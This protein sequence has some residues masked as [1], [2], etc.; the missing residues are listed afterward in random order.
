MAQLRQR[1]K[2]LEN[3]NAELQ[4][5]YVNEKIEKEKIEKNILE[6]KEQW[7]REKIALIELNQK[8][9]VM[10]EEINS[11]IIDYKQTNN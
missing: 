6:E 1:L 2:E 4:K 7:N 5:T 9:S 10:I 8:L 3:K 11:K